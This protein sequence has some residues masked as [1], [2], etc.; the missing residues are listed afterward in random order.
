MKLIAL[1]IS[2]YKSLENFL[3]NFSSSYIVSFN[4]DAEE[5]T[6]EKVDEPVVSMYSPNSNVN[7]LLGDNGTGKTSILDCVEGIFKR[8]DSFG[9]CVIEVAGKIKYFESGHYI[10]KVNGD[11]NLQKYKCRGRNPIKDNLF[12]LKVSNVFDVNNYATNSGRVKKNKNVLDYTNNSIIRKNKSL[13][14]RDDI[15][16]EFRYVNK[17]FNGGD[18]PQFLVNLKLPSTRSIKSEMN[19][20]EK[21]IYQNEKFDI[22]PYISKIE[23]K[24]KINNVFFGD[25]HY[26]DDDIYE[27][28]NDNDELINFI[29]YDYTYEAKCENYCFRLIDII[30]SLCVMEELIYKSDPDSDDRKHLYTRAFLEFYQ[31]GVHDMQ[32]AHDITMNVLNDTDRVSKVIEYYDQLKIVYEIS[33]VLKGLVRSEGYCFDNDTLSIPVVEHVESTLLI[34]HL[35]YLGG[36]VRERIYYGWSGMSS[37]ESAKLKLMARL[38]N[39]LDEIRDLIDDSVPLNPFSYDDFSI[40]VVIDE[41]DLYIHPEWQR[42]LIKEIID[43]RNLSPHDLHIHFI[44]TTHSPIIASDIFPEDIIQLVKGDE[45]VSIKMD[46]LGFG[47]SIMDLY[48]NSF[49]LKSTLGLYSKELID[50]LVGKSKTNDLTAEDI[51]LINRIGDKVVREILLSRVPSH[52]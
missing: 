7:L 21:D 31:S 3:I 16:R 22:Y 14:I 42:C 23:N 24:S 30:L 5:I 37:G 51:P 25:R 20:H 44:I 52:D 39:G 1:Y 9:F 50:G 36:K 4:S 11:G 18:R 33:D 15:E 10:S 45:G 40:I 13:I 46:T 34:N 19:S 35:N 49:S 43:V 38:S 41:I 32:C 8:D 47:T 12:L 17:V 29:M 2:E 26:T 6:I 27:M 48:F 28:L